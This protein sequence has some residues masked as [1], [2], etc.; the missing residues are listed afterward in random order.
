MTSC[1]RRQISTHAPRTGSDLVVLHHFSK[2]IDFN[3]RSPHGERPFGSPG[4]RMLLFDFN[5]RSPHGERLSVSPRLIHSPYFNPRSPHGE[6]QMRLRYS[7]VFLLNFN[8]RSPH[9]ERLD[10]VTVF[11]PLGISTHAPRTGSDLAEKATSGRRQDIS[12]HA[13]RTGSDDAWSAKRDWRTRFQPTLPARGA[14]WFRGLRLPRFRDFNPRSPHGERPAQSAFW[15]LS[16]IFQPTLPA[17]GATK[18]ATT[19]LRAG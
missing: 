5:P 8:P 19:L 7:C 13:P 12:T 6:R 9:G 3:P 16:M 17:R 4:K 15:S 1:K 11:L 18:S 2:R 10:N 14:T